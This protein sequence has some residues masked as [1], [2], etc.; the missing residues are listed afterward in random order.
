MSLFS[1]N[2][3][4][5][6]IVCLVLAGLLLLPAGLWARGD[7]V[8][9]HTSDI[10]GRISPQPDNFSSADPKPLMGGFAAMKTFLHQERLNALKDG[11][12]PVL[13][14][15]GDFF[16]GTPVVE[17]TQGAC[18]ID[19]M[20]QVRY[21]AVCLGNHDFDY[22]PP[23][24]A[25]MAGRSDF[26]FVTANV[27]EQSSGRRPG[28]L[29]PYVKIPYKGKILGL[30]GVLTP[31]TPRMSFDEAVA[32]IE[33]RDPLPAIREAARSLRAQGADVIVLLSH[34]G[35]EADRLLVPRLDKDE[36]DLILGGHSHTL[37]TEPEFPV[38]GGPALIHSG[39][40]G[41]WISRIV[42]PASPQE[43]HKIELT[44]V[45]LHL[46]RYPEDPTVKVTVDRFER[47]AKEKLG[48]LLGHSQ[49]NLFR[50]VVGGDS[51]EGSFV[52]DAMREAAGSDFAFINAGCLRVPI[53]AGPMTLEDVYYLQPFDNLL[54]V[55]TMSGTQIRHMLEQPLSMP[56]SP[57]TAEDMEYSIKNFQSRVEGLKR[58]FQ[59]DFG[60]LFPSNLQVTFDPTR[61][62]GDRILSITDAQGT[63]L[64]PA[65]SYTVAFSDYVA[66]GGDGYQLL[67]D[68]KIRKAL[69]ILVRDAVSRKIERDGGIAKVP[70]QRMFNTKLKVIPAL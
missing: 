10:H 9:F 55:L 2:H 60:Y 7:F 15:S 5:R 65:R 32:G 11:N 1:Q 34:L 8:L 23:R 28:F 46:D 27:F 66:K 59:G 13:I 30:I 4:L 51:T 17:E 41:R 6:I 24:L 31:E 19:L 39:Y 16:Q 49:V 35:I 47:K 40:D 56:F 64:E 25:E 14:D 42:L 45:P 61:P 21:L 63:P 37:M 70:E 36:V 3:S 26:F 54:E 58:D 33:F 62:A 22:R 50:G 44:S 12:L 29:R 57:V 69:P 52:A 20:N 18:M 67:K 43:R 53:L 68:V 48:K 38:P